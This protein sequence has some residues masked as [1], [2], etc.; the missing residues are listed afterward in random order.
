MSL[1]PL[2]Q[3]FMNEM[4]QLSNEPSIDIQI[5]PLAGFALIAQLQLAFRHP[6]NQGITRF[7]AEEVARELQ[8]RICLPRT[9]LYEVT[10]RGWHREFDTELCLKPVFQNVLTIFPV[11]CSLLIRQHR[12]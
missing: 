12:L 1:D 9:A 7:H 11:G 5:S 6:E 4:A 8:A 3:Q 10:E 2:L